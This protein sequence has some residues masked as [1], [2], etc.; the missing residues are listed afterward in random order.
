MRRRK[1]RDRPDVEEAEGKEK[2]REWDRSVLTFLL[3]TSFAIQCGLS[4]TNVG[5][6]SKSEVRYL[7]IL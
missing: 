3:T 1:G 4:P 7:R 6:V 2:E 5:T